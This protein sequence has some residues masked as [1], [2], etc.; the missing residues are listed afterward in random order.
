MT[1]SQNWF[2]HIRREIIARGKDYYL[3]DRVQ[4]LEYEDGIYTAEVD[5]T[6]L[7]NVEVEIDGDELINSDCDCPYDRGICKHVAAV[8][9]AIENGDENITESEDLTFSNATEIKKIT[10]ENM[11]LIL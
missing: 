6:D 1:T 2:K 3:S 11:F 4:N 5:G 10:F 9:F 8:L 7:Y